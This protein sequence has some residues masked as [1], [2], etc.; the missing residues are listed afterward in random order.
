[1]LA[2]DEFLQAD[3]LLPFGQTERVDQTQVISFPQHLTAQQA[4]SE[5]AGGNRQVNATFH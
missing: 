4:F 1:M 3:G 5:A 2:A